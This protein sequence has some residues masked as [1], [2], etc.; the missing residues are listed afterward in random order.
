[1]YIWA[2]ILYLAECFKDLRLSGKRRKNLY[3]RMKTFTLPVAFS[4]IVFIIY[5]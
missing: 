5:V 4:V 1:V 2:F 3:R